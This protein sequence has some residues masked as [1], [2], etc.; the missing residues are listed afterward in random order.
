MSATAA[1]EI[2]Y[3]PAEAAMQTYLREGEPEGLQPAGFEHL[4]IRSR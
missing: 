3:N 1:N 2:D 4:T